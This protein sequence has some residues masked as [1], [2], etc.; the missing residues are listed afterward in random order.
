MVL[1]ISQ[2]KVDL[3]MELIFRSDTKQ[4][5][6]RFTAKH[7]AHPAKMSLPLQ[8]WLIEHYSKPGDVILDPMCGSGTILVACSLSRNVIVVEL[9][10]K[11]VE[12]TEENWKRVQEVG[13]ELGHTMGWAIIKQGDA[14]N[15]EG[16]LA[17]CIIT[18]PPFSRQMQDTEWM[19]KNSPRKHRG[20]REGDYRDAIGDLP[21]G[22]VDAVITSPPYEGS[23][24][25]TA[26]HTKG[27]IPSRDRKLAQTGS[28]AD[29]NEAEVMAKSSSGF[30]SE[31]ALATIRRSARGY[32]ASEDNIGNL[33]SDTY[34][35]AMRQVYS[36]CFK[37]LK[38]D[39]LLVLV[40]KP[41]I[42]DRK[43]VHLEEDTKKLCQAV[44]FTFVEEH[45]RRL[46]SMS[47]WRIIYYAKNPEVEKVDKEYILVFKKNDGL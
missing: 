28:Y 12:M 16:V 8:V 22:S 30:Q 40:V 25:A 15:L 24:E 4:R 29:F 14:R 7:F 38:P 17:D 26:R 42:R 34:L 31:K 11:F 19:R 46:L 45:Y 6:Q 3:A 23:L 39:G 13:P 35:S 18:S 27:G 10:K 20:S 21:Y 41:F 43:I 32:S 9:E 2:V 1:V 44:G 47:F 5:K 37:V 33:R 36:Q